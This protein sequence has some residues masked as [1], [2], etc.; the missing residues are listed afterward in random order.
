[1]KFEWLKKRTLTMLPSGSL[2]VAC[3]TRLLPAVKLAP[4]VGQ[5]MLTTGAAF[6]RNSAL[7]M[8]LRTLRAT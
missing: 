5:T 7:P 8:T 3:K 1:M 2:A 4:L 6:D